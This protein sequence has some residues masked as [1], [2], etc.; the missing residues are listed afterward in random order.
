MF[1]RHRPTGGSPVALSF[2]ALWRDPARRFSHVSDDRVSLC[3]AHGCLSR[4][5]RTLVAL[6]A[7]SQPVSSSPTLQ[8]SLA[9]LHRFRFM[10]VLC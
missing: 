4:P 7:I 8:P 6:A 2:P 3:L 1:M 10:L 5:P 9:R